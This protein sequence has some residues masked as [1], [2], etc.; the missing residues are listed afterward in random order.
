MQIFEAFQTSGE[1]ARELQETGAHWE[2]HWEKLMTRF[3]C[4]SVFF[5][6]VLLGDF[7]RKNM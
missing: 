6:G 2:G 1:K 7:G 5:F 4:C 3:V